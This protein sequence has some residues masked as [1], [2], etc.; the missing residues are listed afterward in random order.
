MKIYQQFPFLQYYFYV[1]PH[2]LL[3]RERQLHKVLFLRQQIRWLHRTYRNYICIIQIGCYYECFNEN[4]VRLSAV[5]GFTIKKNWR[6]FS[7]GCGFPKP[8][9][10]KVMGELQKRYVPFIIVKQTGRELYCAQERLPYLL[11]KYEK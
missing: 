7:Y 1:S 4:A 6:G 8:L 10:E 5:T 3:R 9:L 11:V 2:K